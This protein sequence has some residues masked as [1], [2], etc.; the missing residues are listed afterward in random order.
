LSI[1]TEIGFCQNLVS[2][3]VAYNELLTLPQEITK[4]AKLQTLSLGQ[5]PMQ[6]S[7]IEKIRAFVPQARL[8]F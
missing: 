1:P 4:L 6:R 8:G 3:N 7:E 2:I 5:N